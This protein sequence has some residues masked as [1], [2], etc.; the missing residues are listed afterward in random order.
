VVGGRAA[1]LVVVLGIEVVVGVAM[2]V[3]VAMLVGLTTVVDV[4]GEAVPFLEEVHPVTPKLR[5]AVT[6]TNVI[7]IFGCL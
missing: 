4:A 6:S 3:V 1:R 7:A 5:Q 2:L